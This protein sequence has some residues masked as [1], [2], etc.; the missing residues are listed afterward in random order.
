MLHCIPFMRHR[1]ISGKARFSIQRMLVLLLSILYAA[2]V[3]TPLVHSAF[4]G[5][6]ES[7]LHSEA[8]EKDPCHRKIYHNDTKHGCKHDDHL[9]DADNHCPCGAIHIDEYL[10]SLV[11]ADQPII[12]TRNDNSD[13]RS[14]WNFPSSVSSTR[15]PPSQS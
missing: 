3:Q 2:N 5:H 8:H 10:V 14:D 15:A 7:Q 11:A 6:D 13:G 12:G 9:V 4:H 1:V